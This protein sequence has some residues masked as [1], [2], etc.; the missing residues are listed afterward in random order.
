MKLNQVM[1]IC[2]FLAISSVQVRSETLPATDGPIFLN[3]V[4]DGRSEVQIV[5]PDSAAQAEQIA[6]QKLVAWFKDFMS[7]DVPVKKAGD[8]P[9]APE[10]NLLVLG[11]PDDSPL[12]AELLKSPERG[13]SD[14]P[15]LSEEGFARPD[16]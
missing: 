10:G 12:I 13:I 7:V 15:F 1:M 5:I 4:R 3:V 14:L 6:T 16:G 2:A 11:T 9:A 8:L